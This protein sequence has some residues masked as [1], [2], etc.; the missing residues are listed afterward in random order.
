MVDSSEGRNVDAL[1]PWPDECFAPRPKLWMRLTAGYLGFLTLLASGLGFWALLSGQYR[2]AIFLFGSGVYSGL[3]TSLSLRLLRTRRQMSPTAITLG[4]TESTEDGVVIAYSGWLYSCLAMLI[5]LTLVVLTDLVLSGL[6][7][8]QLPLF[9]SPPGVVSTVISSAFGLYFLWIVI[10]MVSGRLARGRVVLSPDGIY[11]RSLTFEHFAPWHA[12]YTIS[13]EDAGVPLIV[14]K[15]SPC[16]HTRIHRTSW[17]GTQQE[18]KLLPS[19]AVRA[20]SLEVDPAVLYHALRYYHAHPEA[21][22]ELATEAGVRRI[23]TGD[24]LEL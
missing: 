6:A 13:A 9:R 21:R 12:V 11:H 3:V 1:L 7:G 15:V 19:A 10:D 5:L 22:P 24:L 23:Q 8:W 20:P 16:N 2:S 4:K 17:V 14:A 18:F